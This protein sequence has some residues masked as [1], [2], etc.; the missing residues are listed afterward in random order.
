MKATGKHSSARH[1][2]E[3]LASIACLLIGESSTKLS[4]VCKFV[5]DSSARFIVCRYASHVIYPALDALPA[6][7]FPKQWM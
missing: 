2:K 3:G 5:K 7:L 1:V 4:L 6:G